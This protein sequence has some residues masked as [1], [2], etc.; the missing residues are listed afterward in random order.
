M[1][2]ALACKKTNNDDGNLQKAKFHSWNQTPRA[3][4]A[5]EKDEKTT[6]WLL[7][8]QREEKHI[9]SSSLCKTFEDRNKTADISRMIHHL[10]PGGGWSV[11]L[12][13]RESSLRVISCST[14]PAP[15]LWSLFCNGRNPAVRRTKLGSREAVFLATSIG[16]CTVFGVGC[17]FDPNPLPYQFDYRRKK[18]MVILSFDSFDNVKTLDRL[19]YYR[20]PFIQKCTVRY[21]PADSVVSRNNFCHCGP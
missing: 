3:L 11:T 10:C 21:R 18:I 16:G 15:R 8:Q 4:Y 5:F 6:K 17:V 2:I 14:W 1:A 7:C 19:K 13:R 9:I 20:M 12:I